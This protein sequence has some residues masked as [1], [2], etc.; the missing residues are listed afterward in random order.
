MKKLALILACA[1][2]AVTP[3]V[4]RAATLTIPVAVTVNGVDVFAGPQFTVSGNFGLADTFALTADGEV[5]LAGTQFFANAAGVITRPDTTNT[6]AHPGGVTLSGG[7]PYAALLIGNGSLG[8]RAVFPANA[9]NGLGSL[10]PP[11]HLTVNRTIADLFGVAIADGTVLQ[12]RIND[13]N[14]GDNNG[15]FRLSPTTVPEPLTVALLAFGL[16]AAALR[17]RTR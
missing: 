11:T 7:I 6:G 12:F 14:N 5:G 1:V 9:A 16:G 15:G 4:A 17:R 3:T 8:F 10:T 13:I 2:A